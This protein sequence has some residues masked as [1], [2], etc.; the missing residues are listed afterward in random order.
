[1]ENTLHTTTTKIC[2]C[3]DLHQK[4]LQHNIDLTALLEESLRKIFT[5]SERDVWVQENMKAMQ[6]AN[7]FVAEHGIWSDG[8]RAF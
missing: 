7:K 4:A 5:L 8:M 1:M 6:E 2:I 3:T